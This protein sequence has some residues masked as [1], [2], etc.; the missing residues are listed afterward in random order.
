MKKGIA[1]LLCRAFNKV[2]NL[3]EATNEVGEGMWWE[4][5][6]V[7]ILRTFNAGMAIQT[8]AG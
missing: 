1:L 8:P 3:I 4:E 7:R 6:K 5:E 2:K